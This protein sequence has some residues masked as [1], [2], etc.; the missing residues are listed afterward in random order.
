MSALPP[1]P[2]IDFDQS[3]DKA[4]ICALHQHPAAQADRERFATLYRKAALELKR[5][6]R[7][8]ERQAAAKRARRLKHE[9]RRRSTAEIRAHAM[10][11]AADTPE[12]ERRAASCSPVP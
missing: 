1:P 7:R 10:T 6:A 3:D 2:A 12:V 9:I 4:I 5:Q 8:A 11:M